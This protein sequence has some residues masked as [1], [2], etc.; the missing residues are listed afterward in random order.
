MAAYRRDVIAI[1]RRWYDTLQNEDI[2]P[3]LQLVGRYQGEIVQAMRRYH[4]RA[5]RNQVLF[6]R[7]MVVLQSTA[8][9]VP[10]KLDIM[11]VIRDFFRR[12]SPEEEWAAIVRLA[13]PARR[14]DQITSIQTVRTLLEEDL[15]DPLPIRTQNPL[16]GERAHSSEAPMGA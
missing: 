7:V 13:D 4:V 2:P 10:V 8:L 12:R 9:R 16:T 5:Q 1:L 14:L 3:E 15:R 11:K 6:W